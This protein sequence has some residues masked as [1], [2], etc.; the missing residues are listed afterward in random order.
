MSLV[1]ADGQVLTWPSAQFAQ[2][3]GAGSADLAAALRSVLVTDR[4]K[5]LRRLEVWCPTRLIGDQVTI[6]DTPG[7]SV[8]ETGHRELAAAAIDA[9]DLVIVVI[10]AVATTSLTTMDFLSDT[11]RRH[12]DRCVFVITKTDLVEDAELDEIVT[13][14][15]G[16][17]AGAGFL[18]PVVLT[19][20]PEFALRE[21][22]QPNAFLAEFVA[23]EFATS[24]W[25]YVPRSAPAR[26]LSAGAVRWGY[27]PTRTALHEF[28]VPAISAAHLVATVGH[29][30]APSSPLREWFLPAHDGPA[31]CEPLRFARTRSRDSLQSVRA[32]RAC[33]AR[34]GTAMTSRQ[35]AC[36][37]SSSAWTISTAAMRCAGVAAAAAPRISRAASSGSRATH[38]RPAN[39]AATQRT[40][41]SQDGG[42]GWGLT[43]RSRSAERQAQRSNAV[44]NRQIGTLVARRALESARWAQ[45][46]PQS[47]PLRRRQ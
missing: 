39:S 43:L 30:L 15:S 46:A 42:A 32:M 5:Y 2:F 9:A 8:D 17:L 4:A 38:H 31:V 26:D 23:M 13:V 36:V 3:A 6:I 37:G 12:R 27:S 1:T 25:M 45:R 11:T 18:D 44:N 28:V 47:D 34:F 24:A 10:P 29:M 20:T 35:T 40:H 33:A 14:T 19:C 7:F 16:R 21:L 22:A 41:L